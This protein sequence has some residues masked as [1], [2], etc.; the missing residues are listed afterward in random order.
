MRVVI[1]GGAGFIGRAVVER[2]VARGD[3]VVALVRDPLRAQH[4]IRSN[5]ELVQS[6]LA[7]PM[8]LARAFDGADAAIHGAGEYRVGIPERD[9]PAMWDANVGATERVLDAA[10]QAGV[11][12]ILYVSTLNV[13]GNTRGRLVDETYRRDSTDGFL[14][15]YD[16]T[17]VRAHE[18]AEA[19]IKAGTPIVIAMPS[20]VYGPNDHS[21][22]SEQLALA[23]AGRLRYL[24][25]ADL[26]LAWAH[27]HDVADGIVAALDRGRI[28][29][30]YLLAGECRRLDESVAIAA[31]VGGHRPPLLK[32]PTW[33]LRAS[34]PL[35]DAV[36]GLPGMPDNLRET[37]S[38][39]AG[40]TYWGG[41]EKAA[42]ELGFAPRTLDQGIADT[43]GATPTRPTKP[44]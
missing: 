8:A 11:P 7:D 12:R 10:K 37:I 19:R 20:Q 40:V 41:H 29:E 35:N 34:A 15:W 22:A 21:S 3:Q 42:R 32:I 23:H 6:D 28:G 17:K 39:A 9:R 16:E 14:S 43:W 18:S 31:R 33:M 38:S 26:G 25:L 13:M 4:L 24:A 27:V 36:G 2:L 30:A 44:S 1:T 5:V